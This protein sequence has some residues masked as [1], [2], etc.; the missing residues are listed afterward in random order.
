MTEKESYETIDVMSRLFKKDYENNVCVECKTPNPSYVSINNAIFLC[1]KCASRH[2]NLGYNVSYIR[3]LAQKW[4]AYLYSYL[5]RGGN[6]RYI[7]LSKKYDLDKMP[8][9]QKFNTRI[10]EYYRLLIKSEV[11][12]ETPPFEI[13]YEVAKDPINYQINYFP[14]FENYQI[15]E[16]KIKIEKK[17]NLKYI[18]AFRFVGHGLG[19]LATFLGEKYQEYDM[20][21]KIIKGGNVALKGLKAAGKFIAHGIGYLAGQAEKQLFDDNKDD[22]KKEENEENNTNKGN[23]KDN[24]NK[25]ENWPEN[26]INGNSNKTSSCLKREDFISNTV[27][28]LPTYESL[29]KADNIQNNNNN[30][31]NNC[32]SYN[33]NYNNNYNF[34]NAN[35][36]LNTNIF[37][38]NAQNEINQ[39]YHNNN[40]IITPDYV[41]PPGLES[42]SHENSII[43]EK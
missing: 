12:A 27:N 43:G 19:S 32:N 17:N 37:N 26:K 35:N 39:N 6:S 18:E 33:N 41:I 28:E 34:I 29:I 22:G 10:L 2:M 16:G 13:H 36:N 30:Y 11:L 31:N 9:E 14:E 15:Y 4:D 40:K 25:K 38:N 3:H 1:D 42:S 7:R 24:K 5:D 20:N 21:N 8:I 23:N